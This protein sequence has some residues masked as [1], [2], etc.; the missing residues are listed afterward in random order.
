MH[1]VFNIKHAGFEVSLPNLVVRDGEINILKML[2]QDDQTIVAGGGNFYLGLCGNVAANSV[3]SVLSSITDEPGSTGGY[4]RKAVGRNTTGFPTAS[5]TLVN[6]VYRAR[7][8]QVTWTPSGAD[9][10]TAIT[11]VFLTNVSSGTTGVLFAFSAALTSPLIL[12]DG[13]PFNVN[14]DLYLR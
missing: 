2:L 3:A 4:A 9:Y 6:G 13:T 12:T 14:Y 1:G 11:R 7:S 10:D 5:I 8:L